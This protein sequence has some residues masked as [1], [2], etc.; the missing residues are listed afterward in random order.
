MGGMKRAEKG[1]LSVFDSLIFAITLMLVSFFLFNIYSTNLRR[2]FDIRE[3]RTINERVED[4]HETVIHSVIEE[5]G[6]VNK[7]SDRKIQYTNITVEK[8]IKNYLYLDNLEGEYDLSQLREDI[9]KK[10]RLAAWQIAHFHYGVYSSYEDGELFIS[11]SIE[12]QEKIPTER[13]TDVKRTTMGDLPGEPQE[14][15]ILLYLW[16]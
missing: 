1:M 4:I 16:L 2:G 9:E 13:G 12:D 5:S 7:S 14:L 3:A 15:R 10:Y 11:D 6:Y 8:A